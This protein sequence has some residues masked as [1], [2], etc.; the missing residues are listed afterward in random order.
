MKLLIRKRTQLE[1]TADIC[2][3]LYLITEFL[4]KHTIIGQ[5][6]IIVFLVSTTLLMLEKKSMHFNAYYFFYF[7]FIVY[8]YYNV[9]TGYSIHQETA[10][11]M[12]YTLIVNFV[13]LFFLYNFL[14]IR[15]G[16]KVSINIYNLASLILTVII[17]IK[18]TPNL[19][20]QR[21]GGNFNIFGFYISVNAN[22]LA[23]IAAFAF[24]FV[25][26]EFLVFKKKRK[27]IISLWYI[28][29]ILLSGSRKGLL[30]IIVGFILLIY[31]MYPKKRIRNILV[32]IIILTIA[33]LSILYIPSLY[34]LIGY[35][36]EPLINFI[37][38]NTYEEASLE[39][40]VS[41]IELG[42]N[43]IIQR[44]LRGYGLDCFKYLPRAYNTYSHNNYVEILVSSGIVGFILYYFSYVFY[45]IRGMSAIKK[46]TGI[47]KLCFSFII[48][49]LVMDYAMVSYYDRF[50][51][52]ILMF[53]IAQIN[54]SS[55]QF[56]R[57]KDEK[58]DFNYL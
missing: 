57:W 58:K 46:D 12:I 55:K 1:T 43:Y 35:R 29:I 9:R 37:M 10:L 34:N 2:F 26:Y 42:W 13:I 45:I 3:F 48:I 56:R 4:F 30:T 47:V 54:I 53:G 44:P 5:I 40:R 52:T 23:L 31:L 32:T 28:F 33:F 24:L 22:T 27:I 14:M 7:L 15:N 17:F 19:M 50:I 49:I 39:T 18:S 11:E 21:L 38:G 36:I 6:G 8:N 51:L 20:S 25:F 41:F 16:I